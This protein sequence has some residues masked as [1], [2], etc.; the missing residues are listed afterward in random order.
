MVRGASI[1]EHLTKITGTKPKESTQTTA[2]LDQY[3]IGSDGKNFS[4]SQTFTVV[5]DGVTYSNLDLYARNGQHIANDTNII[6][7]SSQSVSV[8]GSTRGVD[9]PC[10]H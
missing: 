6:S 8:N 3:A 2:F 1:T 9:G 10:P 5:F 7:A 4:V